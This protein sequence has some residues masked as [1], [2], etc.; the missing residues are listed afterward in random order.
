[1]SDKTINELREQL[2]QGRVVA[3][4]G[5]G[6]S[7]A[8]T[9]GEVGVATWQGLLCNG[10]E[11]C[12]DDGSPRLPAAD[13]ELCRKMV[14]TGEVD[15]MLAAASVIESRLGA[16][17]KSQWRWWLNGSV[18]KMRC[19]DFRLLEAIRGLGVPIVTTNYDSLLEERKNASPLPAFTWRS[20]AKCVEVLNGE[21]EGVVHLHGWWDEPESVVLGIRSYEAVLKAEPA[22][23]IQRALGRFNSL[24]F[25]GYGAG[26]S[27]PNFAPLLKWFG[28]DQAPN[29]RHYIL[30]PGNELERADEFGTIRPIGYGPNFDFLPKLIESLVSEP[31]EDRTAVARDLVSVVMPGE[32]FVEAETCEIPEMVV[33]EGGSFEMGSRRK[34]EARP[35]ELPVHT[36]TLSDN[37]AVSR[38]PVTF[39][40]WETFIEATGI[41]MLG[42]QD[43]GWGRARRPV[44]NVSWHEA[45]AYLEWLNNLDTVHGTYR[46]LTEAEWEYVARAGSSGRYWWGDEIDPEQ[47]NYDEANLRGTTPVDRYEPNPFGLY[48]VLGNI[49]EWT[50]DYFHPNYQGAPT[51][52][53]QWVEGGTKRVVRG[54]CWYYDS[55]YLEAGA[56]LAIEPG[57]RFNSIGFRIARTIR[58]TLRSGGIYRLVAVNSSL[59]ATAAPDGTVSQEIYTGSSEQ[60]WELN[61]VED[62]IFTIG[63]E[64]RAELL[65]VGEPTTRNLS[66]IVLGSHSGKDVQRWRA[67]AESDGYVFENLHSG[68]A[69]DVFGSFTEPGA[70]LI[71]FARHGNA[72]QRW[73]VRLTG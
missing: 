2:A 18:G 17:A 72:N 13:Q 66:P 36:V 58:Q 32:S 25:I 16:P 10:F 55:E 28:D 50:A 27:D 60:R 42:S 22:Q 11:Y 39:D 65:G 57:A 4:V 5:T 67:I 64:D 45:L 24:L 15:L 6:F 70:R 48:D 12:G 35:E 61:E 21:R 7:G 52:G 63:P 19:T 23:E 56:R 3:V 8:A 54:G 9:G 20:P 59:A 49:W 73:W 1:M 44:I 40:E 30:L 14:E 34:G 26:L 43:C 53:S 46:L 38:Y 71:Q 31:E 29:H 51:D 33:V 68:K 37:F 69:L 62:A 41:R 47:A